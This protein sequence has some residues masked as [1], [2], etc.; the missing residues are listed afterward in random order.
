MYYMFDEHTEQ[1]MHAPANVEGKAKKRTTQ[2][3]GHDIFQRSDGI[4]MAHKN[5]R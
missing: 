2:V 3:F 4:L 5:T 1:N